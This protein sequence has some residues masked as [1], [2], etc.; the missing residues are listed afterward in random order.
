MET[1]QKK[2]NGHSGEAEKDGEEAKQKQKKDDTETDNPAEKESD[3]GA[4]MCEKYSVQEEI[5]EAKHFG[6]KMALVKSG[7]T[8]SALGRTRT[9][10]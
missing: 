3:R 8:N 1:C 10:I 4:T 5:C 6:P 9:G 7:P 2:R